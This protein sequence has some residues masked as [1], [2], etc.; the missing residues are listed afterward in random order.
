VRVAA[1]KGARARATGA[2]EHVRLAHV[3]VRG[4]RSVGDVAFSPGPVCALVGEAHAG[5]SN[6]LAAIRALLD[7]EATPLRDEDAT[8][9]GTGRIRIDG[10]LTNGRR[11]TVESPR[12]RAGGAARAAAPPVLFLPASLR[13]GAVLA[14]SRVGRDSVRPLVEL[15]RELVE[16][17][18]EAPSTTAAARSFVERLERWC[19]QGV[20]G[21]VLLIEEP[22]LYLRPQS[23][24][25]LYRLLRTF[26]G[27]GNQVIYSTHAPAF[28]NVAR[29]HE[30][31]LVERHPRRGTQVFQ[32]RRAAPGEALRV[33]SEFDAERSELFLARAAVLVEGRTEK[34]ALPFVFRALGHD[35]D[36]EAISIVECGGKGNIPLFAR[37]CKTAGV[38]FLVL[39]DRD[40]PSREQEPPEARAL[41]ELIAAEAG[42]ERTIVLEP[43]FEPV[44]G[45]HR[46]GHK[47]E[48]AWR[49]FASLS[50]KGVPEPLA[51]AVELAVQLARE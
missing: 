6:L 24:R 4:F 31:A 32:P 9:G 51:R 43:E 28:L 45:L 47:P 30:L 19:G 7:P 33:L 15:L 20:A 13:A 2:P 35:A 48:H 39:H 26:A 46:R 42:P 17:P 12:S 34:L 41:N 3:R 18:L 29:L 38:P 36:R 14:P 22:E 1:A 21:F 37:V 27:S 40:A 25:Y 5:K 8:R 11:L 10:A 23:Q 44:A 49:R 50:R 16:E